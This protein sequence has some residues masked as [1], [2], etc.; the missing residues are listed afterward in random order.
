MSKTT[1]HYKTERKTTFEQERK[2]NLESFKGAEIVNNWQHYAFNSGVDF[3]AKR[4]QKELSAEAKA[5]S[6]ECQPGLLRAIGIL[7]ELTESSK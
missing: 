4:L 2:L 1:P 3:L 5:A 6:D 7:L